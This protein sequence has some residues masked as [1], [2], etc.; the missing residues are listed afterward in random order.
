MNR[1]NALYHLLYLLL[2]AVVWYVVLGFIMIW[3]LDVR[4]HLKSLTHAHFSISYTEQDPTSADSVNVEPLVASQFFSEHVFQFKDIASNKRLRIL[5]DDT[6]D[7]YFIHQLQLTVRCGFFTRQLDTLKGRSL[8]P[9]IQ[10]SEL[11]AGVSDHF[12]VVNN[13]H[14]NTFLHF[15]QQLH[16]QIDAVIQSNRWLQLWRVFASLILSITCI[17]LFRSLIPNR[18]RKPISLYIRQLD[19][20]SAGIIGI[21]FFIF[22]NG[23]LRFIPDKQSTENRNL[24]AWVPLRIHQFFSWPDQLSNYVNDHFAFRNYLFFAHSVL[25]AKLFKTASLPDRIIYGKRDWFFEVDDF[26]MNDYRMLN[27][28]TEKEL[29]QLTTVV[30][31]RVR[32]LKSRGISYYIMVPPNRNRVYPELFPA[33]YTIPKNYGHNRLDFFKKYLHE[34]IGFDL[35]DPS[36]ALQQ[37]KV[38]HDVYYSTDSH[39][40]MFGAWVG[41]T[42]A[43]QAMQKNYP[44]LNPVPYNQLV[45][46]DSFNNRGDLSALLG[47]ENVFK[48]KEYVVSL[49]DTSRKLNMPYSSDILMRFTNNIPKDSCQLKL[50]IFRDSYSNYLI[51]YFNLHFKEVVC[52]WSYDF[53]HE[54]I[55]TE[56]P[57]I[58]L[59]EVQQRAMVYGLLNDNLFEK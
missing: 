49:K 4:I 10:E 9:Y 29:T 34:T 6:T 50:M 21:L 48:R 14:R 22:L 52:V 17:L 32:W 51:P 16:R 30:D 28:F 40:N 25:K 33:R 41:Y 36:E 56:K 1:I 13:R 26:A 42:T 3:N 55:E 53:L 35:I 23:L 45:I 47:L 46:T 58:V 8:L 39:W 18:E 44:C 37:H 38:K 11:I 54:L 7:T 19:T 24:A 20:L 27:R 2:I 43:M 31:E 15:N 57:D 12:I 5:F 59:L